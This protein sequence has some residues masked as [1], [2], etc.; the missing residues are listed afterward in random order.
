MYL[1]DIGMSLAILSREIEIFNC[2]CF[3]DIN[4]V[5]E[6]FYAQLLNKVYGYN[7]CNLNAFEKNAPA[8]DL[9]DKKNRISIQVTSDNDSDKIKK[10]IYKFIEYNQYSIYDKLIILILTKKKKYRTEFDTQN[11][12][13]FDKDKHIIDYTDLVK[14]IST[15][16]S[17]E[18]L[19]ISRFLESEF[20]GRHNRKEHTMASEIETIIEL[21]E[22]ISKNRDK[23]EKRDVVID[24]EYKIDYRFKKFAEKLKNNYLILHSLYGEALETIY[25]TL[26]IDEAQDIITALYLQDISIKMLEEASNNPIQALE[27]LVDYFAEKLGQN[28]KKYDKAAIKYYLVQEL[29]KCNVF[30]NE[31][32]DIQ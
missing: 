24:P 22:Y 13:H 15:K 28:G 25:T 7:L 23:K 31:R 21:I 18:L 1:K 27:R 10:T 11:L 17:T 9:G 4:H 5:A 29:I 2:V 20:V 14:D 8:I 19:D 3:Y 26:E 32:D 30:P 6:D 16:D 12:F